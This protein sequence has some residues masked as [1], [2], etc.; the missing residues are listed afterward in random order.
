MRELIK[1][2]RLLSEEFSRLSKPQLEAIAA[3]IAR[4]KRE[5][6]DSQ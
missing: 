2:R 4:L 6:Q 1:L 3:D 5:T